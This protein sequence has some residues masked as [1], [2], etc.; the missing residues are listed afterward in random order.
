MIGTGKVLAVIPA[1]GGSKGLPGKNIRPLAG[2]PLIAHSIKLAAMCREIDRCI[3]STDSPKIANIARKFGGDVPFMRPAELARS[4]TPM[5]PVLKHALAAA[6]KLDG[7]RYDY[8]V[9]LDPTSPT[10]LPQDI[11]DAAKKLT[12]HPKADGIVSASIPHFSPIWHTAVEKDGYLGDF[13]PD[14]ERYTRR[15]DVPEVYVINGLLYIWRT[16]IV[17]EK[18]SWRDVGRHLIFST[19]EAR[20]FS[21][22]TIDEFRRAEI[23]IKSGF[24]QLP[25]LKRRKSR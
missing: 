9:L 10:R 11:R 2:L 25:W 17:R 12:A 20:A 16:R 24:I 21:I 8:L 14:A 7:R 1:R 5:W 22:D 18:D 15:Q 3:I 19:P 6:E 23:L 4:E 13:I